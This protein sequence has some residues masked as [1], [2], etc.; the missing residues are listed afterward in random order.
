[1]A[2]SQNDCH[3]IRVRVCETKQNKI[4]KPIHGPTWEQRW[5]TPIQMTFKNIFRGVCKPSCD[6]MYAKHTH[7][8][9]AICGKINTKMQQC[10]AMSGLNSPIHIISIECII[11]LCRHTFTSRKS[12]T[13]TQK[14]FI[15]IVRLLFRTYQNR[16]E[17]NTRM[18]SLPN[19]NTS[20]SA[21]QRKE[22]RREENKHLY[23]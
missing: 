22:K 1:M 13:H 6:T 11:H 18:V 10:H 5:T 19:A 20:T 17:L 21:K 4:V 16:I 15:F 12:R 8:H 14:T 9:G 7:T 23:K 2:R 3:G